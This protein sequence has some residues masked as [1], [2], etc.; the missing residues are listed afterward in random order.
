MD[1]TITLI[2]EEVS[3][4]VADGTDMSAFVVHPE[5][6]PKAGLIVFQEA[7][8]VNAHIRDVTKRFAAEGYLAIAPELYHRT[9]PGFESGYDNL[10]DNPPYRA[11]MAALTDEGLL[12]DATAAYAWLVAQNIPQKNIGAIG[13]CMG[14]RTAFLAN[15]ILPLAGAVSYYGGGIAQTLLDRAPMQHGPLL[16]FWGGKD[17]HI[18]LEN[19][20]AIAEALTKAGK[21]FENVEFAD[22]GHGFFCDARASY[23]AAA[24]AEAWTQTLAFLKDSLQR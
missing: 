8:G 12:A 6:A 18:P 19:R 24:A 4:H 2:T 17:A 11:H 20:T 22:A 9:G 16:M 3:L 13:Y 5:K 21:P 15:S 1:E 7:F 23:N 10:G 14:G